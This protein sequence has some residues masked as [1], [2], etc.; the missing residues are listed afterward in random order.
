MNKLTKIIRVRLS[1]EDVKL[2]VNKNI[3]AFV[4][5]AVLAKLSQENKL[6]LPF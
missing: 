3:S 5:E 1:K 6:K 2:I 4:R